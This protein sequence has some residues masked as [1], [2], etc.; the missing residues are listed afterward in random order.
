MEFSNNKIDE[1]E[2][3]EMSTG[4]QVLSFWR[5]YPSLH[6]SQTDFILYVLFVLLLSSLKSKS[7]SYG[8]SVS[9]LKGVLFYLPKGV[10]L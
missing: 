9:G 4:T 1:K 6:L 7:S 10:L 2:Q 3:L 8:M 5:I